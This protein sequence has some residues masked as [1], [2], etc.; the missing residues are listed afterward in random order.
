V[1]IIV[2]CIHEALK[3]TIVQKGER[4]QNGRKRVDIVLKSQEGVGTVE[5]VED[6]LKE[7]LN[8]GG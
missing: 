7:N 8:I 1:T 4:N 2:E 6:L 3:T 5:V